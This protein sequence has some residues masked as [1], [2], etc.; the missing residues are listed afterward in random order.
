MRSN[1]DQYFNFLLLSELVGMNFMFLNVSYFSL[2]T[3]LFNSSQVKILKGFIK[4]FLQK[5]NPHPFTDLL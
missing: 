5:S 4:V 3:K 2:V 1:Y